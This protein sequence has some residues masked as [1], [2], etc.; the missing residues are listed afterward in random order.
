M[1]SGFSRKEPESTAMLRIA[2]DS[3]R[4]PADLLRKSGR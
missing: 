1:K 4:N 3:W 2:A